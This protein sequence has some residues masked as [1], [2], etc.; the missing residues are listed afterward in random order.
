MPA[1]S[2]STSRKTGAAGRLMADLEAERRAV[3]LLVN[4]AGF[5]LTGRFAELDAERQR[6]MID[7]KSAR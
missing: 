4:N 6:E 3:E 7:L 2:R 1:R 5:G